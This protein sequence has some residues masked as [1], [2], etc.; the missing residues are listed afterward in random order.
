MP[1]DGGGF[2]GA[3]LQRMG[4]VLAVVD[5]PVQQSEQASGPGGGGRVAGGRIRGGIGAVG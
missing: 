4:E 5:Q 1:C 3:L 2:G